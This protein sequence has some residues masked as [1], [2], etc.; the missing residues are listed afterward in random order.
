MTPFIARLVTKGF[1][2][3]EVFYCS[4]IFS[5]VVKPTTICIIPT[6][7]LLHQWLVNQIDI[8]NVFLYNDL[9]EIVYM[10]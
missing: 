6:L 5:P 4:K 1:H 7:A 2:Q 10:M 8:N 9:D 3:R